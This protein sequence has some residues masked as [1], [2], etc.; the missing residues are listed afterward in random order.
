MIPKNE[1]VYAYDM[2][3]LCEG[4]LE[5]KKRYYLY[6]KPNVKEKELLLCEAYAR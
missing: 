2:V 5:S 3:A 4:N 1:I 6:R